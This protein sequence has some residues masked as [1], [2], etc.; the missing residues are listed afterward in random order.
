MNSK[1]IS[2]WAPILLGLGAFLFLSTVF[3]TNSSCYVKSTIG[4][5]CPGCGMTRAYLALLDGDLKSAFFWHPL[6]WLV[7]VYPMVHFGFI[8]F[9]KEKWTKFQLPLLVFILL[10]S[11]YIWRMLLHFP[12]NP[13]MDY[14]HHSLIKQLIDFILNIK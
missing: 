12:N 13:P 2:F 11:V 9:K 1:K 8:Y 7:V 5:P 4:I 14:N 3:S 10:I 6:W